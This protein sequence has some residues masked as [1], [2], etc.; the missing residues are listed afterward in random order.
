MGALVAVLGGGARVG[1]LETGLGALVVLLNVLAGVVLG[2]L[3][4]T[5]GALVGVLGFLVVTLGASVVTL[6]APVV[7]H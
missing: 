6:G 5:L 1:I 2:A 3:V 4:V 7:L